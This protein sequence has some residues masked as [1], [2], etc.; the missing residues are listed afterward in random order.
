MDRR[1]TAQPCEIC[2]DPW[3]AG[4]EEQA[5]RADSMP[6]RRAPIEHEHLEPWTPP[7]DPGRE[8]FCAD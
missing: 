2:R 1:Y 8:R 5:P 7:A 4:C 3:C 6:R